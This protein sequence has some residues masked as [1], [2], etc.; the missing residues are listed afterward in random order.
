MDKKEAIEILE[1]EKGYAEEG[2]HGTP[3]TAEALTLAIDTLKRIEV[4]KIKECLLRAKIK[5]ED[6]P[7]AVFTYLTE[8]K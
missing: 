2:Y 7:Q 3:R 1:E 6:A 8:G 5:R 4:F